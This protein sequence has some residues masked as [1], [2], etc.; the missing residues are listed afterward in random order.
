MPIGLSRWGG[1]YF[2]G[3]FGIFLINLE[4]IFTR[5]NIGESNI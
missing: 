3:F 2:W 1:G 4:I 5:E